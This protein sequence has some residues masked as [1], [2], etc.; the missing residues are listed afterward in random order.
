MNAKINIA[1]VET[2]LPI[3]ASARGDNAYYCEFCNFCGHR[4]SYAACLDRIKHG[5]RSTNFSDCTTAIQRRH[6]P[7]MEMRA[8]EIEAGKALF[9]ISRADVHY[10]VENRMARQGV[11]IN[12]N[13]TEKSV[14]TFKPFEKD[15]EISVPVEPS[16][17]HSDRE[18][19]DYAAAI[20][21]AMSSMTSKKSSNPKS[22][23]VLSNNSVSTDFK[24]SEIKAS[25]PRVPTVKKGMT[26][27]EIAQLMS[28]KK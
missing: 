20:N 3:E 10:E 18:V 9:Y 1:N 16:K 7:A 4:P 5:V 6:C 19:S 15:V 8:Q 11:T 2:A 17:P 28:S 22:S 27:A 24:K 25:K 12:R 14:I 13:A 23:A 26:L 21:K